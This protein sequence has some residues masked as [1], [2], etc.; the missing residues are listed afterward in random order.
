M[1]SL[2]NAAR[3]AAALAIAAAAACAPT[4]QIVA[5]W[6]N[7]A[8]PAVLEKPL[9]VFTSKSE[10]LRRSVEDEL[11]ARIPGAVPGYSVLSANDMQDVVKAREQVKNAGF[12]TVIVT[13]LLDVNQ[14]INVAPGPYGGYG[15]GPMFGPWGTWDYGWGYAPMIDTTTVVTVETLVYTLDPQFGGGNGELLFATQSETFDP[16]NVPNLADAVVHGS[17]K[18]MAKEGVAFSTAR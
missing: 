14:R 1:L 13:R 5:Q 18:A 11:A 6:R 10:T 16:R 4:T 9:V 17:M 12:D 2:H 8:A 15:Y 3:A 7:P